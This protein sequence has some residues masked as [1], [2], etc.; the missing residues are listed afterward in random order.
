MNAMIKEAML[1]VYLL[2]VN[3]LL[4]CSTIN[5]S[6][7]S[8]QQQQD[9]QA[10]ANQQRHSATQYSTAQCSGQR[11]CNGTNTPAVAPIQGLNV[12]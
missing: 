3:W 6:L 2:E 8:E 10:V 5:L 12:Q 9:W 4:L 7:R 11:G 1:E